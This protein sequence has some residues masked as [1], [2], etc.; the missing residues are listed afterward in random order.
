MLKEFTEDA[1]ARMEKAVEHIH[2]EFAGIR[3][4]RASVA[5][6]DG[7]KVEYYGTMTPLNQVASISIPEPRLITIQPWDKSMVSA[8]ERA[9]LVADLGLNPGNDGQ[10][11][12][13][14]IPPLTDERRKELIRFMHKLAE[15]GRVA[16][17]NV[18]RDVNEQIKKSEAAHELSEDNAKRGLENIQEITNKYIAEIDELVKKKEVDI[19][20]V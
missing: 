7:I 1:A 5:L 12:R 11:I 20:E 9:I 4:G 6:L 14:P 18:R 13:I 10:I 3:T 15:E 8:I 19:M 16:V 2:H 17:R